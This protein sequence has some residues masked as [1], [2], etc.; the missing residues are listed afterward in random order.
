MFYYY[1]RKFFSFYDKILPKFVNLFF[2]FG[3]E[4]IKI[5]HSLY[6]PLEWTYSDEREGENGYLKI[7]C[8]KN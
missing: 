5:Y 2:R 3:E 1:K 8:D 7:I 6:K 4:N